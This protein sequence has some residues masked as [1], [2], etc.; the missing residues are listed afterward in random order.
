[1]CVYIKIQI[2]ETETTSQEVD[3]NASDYQADHR[4]HDQSFSKSL[5]S[6]KKS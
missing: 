6:G 2:D 4:Y 1:M 5:M 3:E